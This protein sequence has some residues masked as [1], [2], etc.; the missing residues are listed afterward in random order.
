M[1][2]APT[3]AT[4]E[5]VFLSYAKADGAEFA[6]RLK[7]DLQRNGIKVWMDDSDLS[8]GDRF[9]E[10]IKNAL[11]EAKAV[12]VVLTPGAVLSAYVE[13]EWHEAMTRYTPIL[14]LLAHE[15]EVPVGL[16]SFQY[17]DF[18]TKY[19]AQFKDLVARLLTLADAHLPY[20]RSA[21]DTMR[22][23]RR[24]APDPKRFDP[25][26]AALKAKIAEFS[27]GR[28]DVEAGSAPVGLPAPPDD[29]TTRTRYR[30]CRRAGA[31][32]LHGNAGVPR[33]RARARCPSR[34]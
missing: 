30:R 34:A 16:R 11:R 2:F 15:C 28:R 25:P 10:Q 26:I 7:G 29:I 27:V 12:L 1:S 21:L 3:P 22:K 31:P 9:P 17:L 23:M 6:D 20:L 19:D 5:H 14:P 8:V 24:K 13:G 18:R 32:P 4:F 33:P